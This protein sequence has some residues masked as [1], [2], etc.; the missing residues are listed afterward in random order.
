MIITKKIL[1][2]KYE[3]SMPTL[4]KWLANIPELKLIRNQR[5]FTPKQTEIIYSELGKP[6]G[7]VK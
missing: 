4:N 7:N 3:V 2:Q 1:A 6:D 5:V